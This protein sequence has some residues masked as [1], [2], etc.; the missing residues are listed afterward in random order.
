VRRGGQHIARVP[1]L[2]LVTVAPSLKEA[3]SQM[4]DVI[5]AHIHYIVAEKLDVPELEAMRDDDSTTPCYLIS[6]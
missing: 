6:A 3:Q 2:G 4:L 5:A 1:E